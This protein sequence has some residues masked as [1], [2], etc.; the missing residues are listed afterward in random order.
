M[1]ARRAI[2]TT[3]GQ[4]HLHPKSPCV[5]SVVHIQY[6]FPFSQAAPPRS[7]LRCRLGRR[8]RDLRVALPPPPS[9]TRTQ[10]PNL[11][12]RK[13][14]RRLEQTHEV[15]PNEVPL[16]SSAP[17]RQAGTR[18]LG[19]RRSGVRVWRYVRDGDGILLI[20][21]TGL[22]FT[23]GCKLV[24]HR[25]CVVVAHGSEGWDVLDEEVSDGEWEVPTHVPLFGLVA[26]RGSAPAPASMVP[27]IH[28]PTAGLNGPGGGLMFPSGTMRMQPTASPPPPPGA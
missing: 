6:L 28:P 15:P 13:P 19:Q 10:L 17:A 24:C 26:V 4:P 3:H 27:I 11:T 5:F 20:P 8:K 14:T 16:T 12:P 2:D 21:D 25:R 22:V 9:C 7:V 18:G 1:H 23:C